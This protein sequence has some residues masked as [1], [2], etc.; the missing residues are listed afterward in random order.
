MKKLSFIIVVINYKI[1]LP[2]T[3][4]MKLILERW[5]AGTSTEHFSLMYIHP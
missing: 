1:T 2:F 3:A 4:G 5:A